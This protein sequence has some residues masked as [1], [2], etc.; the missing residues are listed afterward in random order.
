VTAPAASAI[1]PAAFRQQF[2]IFERLRFINSCSKGALSSSVRAAMDEYFQVWDLDGSPWER[3]GQWVEEARRAFARLIGAAPHEVGVSF[4]ASTAINSVVSALDFGTP[5]NGIVVGDLEFP[6]MGHIC[7][8]QQ[9]RGARVTQ[10]HGTDA[11][12]DARTY[13]EA[14]D[15][16]TLLVPL[17]HVS[18]RTGLRLPV[19]EIADAAH[20]AG[21]LVLLDAYQTAGTMPL[22]VK[23]LGVDMLVSGCLKYLLGPPGGA[24]VYVR[25]DLIER[26]TPTITGWHAQSQ[27]AMLDDQVLEYAPDARRF[28][29]GTEAAHSLHGAVAGVQLLESVGLSA[30]G[31]WIEQLSGRAIGGARARGLRS[32]T[33]EDPERRG[34]MVCVAVPDPAAAVAALAAQHIVTSWRGDGV[35]LSFHYYNTFEDVD[36]ALDALAAY[37]GQTLVGERRT[38]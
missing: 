38:S 18:Y 36:A 11:G 24:F 25:D 21:A 37:V 33:P 22:D 28:Q 10:V 30:I 16:R 19:R 2:P 1:S 20:A 5:R 14:I 6:T 3:W 15:Q 13:A 4:G 8:A 23:Q 35:R 17:T 26:L 31:D 27:R 29:M 7:L 34:A 12:L 32:L 9:Q